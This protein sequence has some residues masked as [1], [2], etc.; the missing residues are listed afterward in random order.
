MMTER[1]EKW[2]ESKIAAV[3]HRPLSPPS[4]G[5]LI[6]HMVNSE[7]L[8]P[9]KWST[10]DGAVRLPFAVEAIDEALCGGAA[11]IYLKRNKVPRLDAWMSPAVS[12]CI[13]ADL[14]LGDDIYHPKP[15]DFSHEAIAS[16]FAVAAGGASEGVFDIVACGGG[17]SIYRA[18]TRE[19]KMDTA[20][21]RVLVEVHS[22]YQLGD[23]RTGPTGLA[24]RTY[25][26]AHYVMQFGEDFLLRTPAIVTPCGDG[27][28]I[29]LAE[30]PW[31]LTN[32][33]VAER[34]TRAMNHL[35]PAGIFAIP[36]DTFT[37][38]TKGPNC[39]IAYAP[40]VMPK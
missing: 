3:G 14:V 1:F 2:A 26:G 13:S 11:T 36:N 38:W 25:L 35:R 18:G 5:A 10:R 24:L 8:T 16:V 32:E 20:V 12:F 39:Q 17:S 23:M 28:L 30:E 34:W 22:G 31:T 37:K 7:F 15:E 29:D 19:C 33:E 4:V 21:E 27:L 40:R 9:Q 6:G